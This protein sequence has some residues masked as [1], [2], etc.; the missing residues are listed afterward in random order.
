MQLMALNSLSLFLFLCSNDP[1]TKIS[2]DM[3]IEMKH[4]DRFYC[5]SVPAP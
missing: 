2:T 1:I 4:P 3:I 5:S